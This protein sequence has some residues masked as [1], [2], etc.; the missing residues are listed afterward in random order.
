[1]C[2]HPMMISAAHFPVL[3]A[4]AGSLTWM[5]AIVAAAT[6]KVAVSIRA[7]T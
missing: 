2:D 6:A 7:T 5:V 3:G 4:G 1:M